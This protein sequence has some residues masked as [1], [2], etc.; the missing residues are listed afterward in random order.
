L[1]SK[2]NNKNNLWFGIVAVLVILAGL[3]WA[4]QRT[5][6]KPVAPAAA[7]NRP[8]SPIPPADALASNPFVLASA[9]TLSPDLFADPVARDTYQAAPRSS[10]AVAV[11]L[12]LHAAFRPLEQSLL[13]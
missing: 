11:L 13:L 3:L 10:G 8:A 9:G 1:K 5:E 4:T 12:R 2:K 7:D 6:V